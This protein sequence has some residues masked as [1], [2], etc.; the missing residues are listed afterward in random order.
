MLLKYVLF[1][2]SWILRFLIMMSPRGQTM[3]CIIFYKVS[4]AR[5]QP[6][7]LFHNM[8]I[9]VFLSLKPLLCLLLAKT[10]HF[11]IKLW[12]E[13]HWCIPLLYTAGKGWRWFYFTVLCLL[14]DIKAN[15]RLLL[16]K[17]CLEPNQLTW[18]FSMMKSPYTGFDGYFQCCLKWKQRQ[19]MIKVQLTLRHQPRPRIT[20]FQLGL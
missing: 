16:N 10:K 11:S 14:S 15:N 17:T 4:V 12:A 8:F 19:T 2:F 6:L 18:L 7:E 13:S 20:I 1:A 9:Q 5:C 3:E